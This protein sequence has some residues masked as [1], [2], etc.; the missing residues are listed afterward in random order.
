M[1]KF[2]T[3]Y[4]FDFVKEEYTL[5]GVF[6]K[7]EEAERHM[8]NLQPSPD[9]APTINLLEFSLNEIKDLLMKETFNKINVSI[10]KILKAVESLP[11]IKEEGV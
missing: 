6:T 2:W 4:Q 3:V 7:K 9:V 1:N 8:S 5:M 10:E 11:S